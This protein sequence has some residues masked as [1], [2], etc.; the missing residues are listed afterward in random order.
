MQAA[1]NGFMFGLMVRTLGCGD[2]GYDNAGFQRGAEDESGFRIHI[3]ALGKVIRNPL[4]RI[5][6]SEIV[7]PGLLRL[8]LVFP[9]VALEKPLQSGDA[10]QGVFAVTIVWNAGA[11]FAPD[12]L[13]ANLAAQPLDPLSIDLHAV[14]PPQNRHQTATSKAWIDHV[15]LRVK[16]V[17]SHSFIVSPFNLNRKMKFR[18][19]RERLVR[20]S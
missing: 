10:A 14:I 9:G 4:A 8:W 19:L 2:Q 3:H 15:D 20:N 7:A 13:M 11:W 5:P 12:R 16:P 18:L 17:Y 1:M 6:G